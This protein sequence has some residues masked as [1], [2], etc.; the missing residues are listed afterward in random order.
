MRWTEKRN[1][2][3]VLNAISKKTLDVSSLITDRVPLNDY[4]KI[5]G[6]MSNSKS[7]AS[8]LEYSSS[9]EQKSTI[10]LVEKSFQGKKGVV[11]IIG[12]GNFTSSTILPN[13]KKINANIKYIASSGGYLL[14]SWQKNTA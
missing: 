14:Q 6:D 7:I 1:F 11:G 5:Y 3:A 2:E 13:L 8:I 10:K 4:Q 9:E 12:A